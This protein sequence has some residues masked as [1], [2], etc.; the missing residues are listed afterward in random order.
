MDL[1]EDN[2]HNLLTEAF[3]NL[4]WRSKADILFSIASGLKSLHENNL[5]HCDLHSGNILLFYNFDRYDYIIDLDSSDLF[6]GVLEKLD[7]N[8]VDNNVMRQ[9]KVADQNQRNTSKSQKKELFEKFLHSHPQSCYVSRS[10]H[11]LHGLH[12]LLDEIKSGKSS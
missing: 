11:T 7:D 3:W 6:W 5:V 4:W 8:I 10:I 1:F 9:L 2:L 12:D